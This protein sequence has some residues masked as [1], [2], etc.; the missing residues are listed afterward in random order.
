MIVQGL[1]L[2]AI[3][4]GTV[5]FFLLLLIFLTGNLDRIV[6]VAAKFLPVADEETA[7]SAG[8]SELKEIAAA[9]F[10]AAR[11]SKQAH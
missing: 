11:L 1:V 7:A 8:R 10:L 2:T 5:F 4:M 9:V 6:S 3:G